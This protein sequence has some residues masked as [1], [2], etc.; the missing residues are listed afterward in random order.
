MTRFL[1]RLF[2]YGL[3]IALS[4]E[5]L[6]RAF[7]L[8]TNDPP[9]FIDEKGVEKRVPGHTGFSVTGNRRQNF[10]RFSI[11]QAGF[12]SYREFTPSM[13]KYDIA[14]IGD[15]FIEGFHVDYDESTGKKIEREMADT[16]AVFEYGYAGYDMANQLHLV[17]AYR[18]TFQQMDAIVVYTDFTTDLDRGAYEPNTGRI[19]LLSSTKFKIRDN[20]K[21]L[22]Y[23]SKIGLLDRILGIGPQG[24]DMMT[25]GEKKETDA[26]RL[27]NLKALLESYPLDPAKTYFLCDKRTTN[28]ATMS[29]LESRGF[30]IMDFGVPFSKSELPTTLIY[31]QHW[32]HHGR[33]LIAELIAKNLNQ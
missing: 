15:S 4:L 33:Q 3:L 25:E 27:K 10:S 17:H 22:S 16:V 32:N 20:I 26:V 9:R 1:F 23:V 18:E 19:A 21:L 13:T 8:Y 29:F 28:R 6:V 2:L 31:D 30:T 12:N 11:N 14:L 7:H 24:Q 5:L